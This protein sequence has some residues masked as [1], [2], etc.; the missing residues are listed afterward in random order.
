M[1]DVN[2]WQSLL[3]DATSSGA[4]ILAGR[5]AADAAAAVTGRAYVAFGLRSREN[6]A[7]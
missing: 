6:V 2:G 1:Y 3:V 4:A 7:R 5:G